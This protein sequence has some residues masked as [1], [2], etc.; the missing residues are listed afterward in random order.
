[1]CWYLVW[2]IRK[3][4]TKIISFLI[5]SGAVISF[6]ETFS[7]HI[8]SHTG[9]INLIIS[10]IKI[11]NIEINEPINIYGIYDTTILLNFIPIYGRTSVRTSYFQEII[12][13]AQGFGATRRLLT[14]N[15]LD[16]PYCILNK[17]DINRDIDEDGWTILYILA[18]NFTEFQN[19]DDDCF[20]A[21]LEKQIENALSSSR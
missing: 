4:S 11:D 13:T 20:N 9:G 8:N 16:A 12:S 19:W 15:E 5:S 6:I 10:N 3:L 17:Y 7:K 21:I 18:S 1:M 14:K 2:V